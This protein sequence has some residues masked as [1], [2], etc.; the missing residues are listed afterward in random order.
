MNGDPV[1][2]VQELGQIIEHALL[3]LAQQAKKKGKLNSGGFQSI[4]D[5]YPQ[6]KLIGDL[7]RDSVIDASLLGRCRGFADDR[8]SVSHKPRTLKKAI[9]REQ[10]IKDCWSVG[11]RILRELPARSKEKGFVFR[12]Q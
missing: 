5:Y 9:E 2:G 3:H 11:L 7:T 1:H 6:A 4:E 10:T 12:V 8:N